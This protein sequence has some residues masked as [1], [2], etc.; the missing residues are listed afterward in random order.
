[1][2]DLVF[3]KYRA[4]V[5]AKTAL[6]GWRRGRWRR[7]GLSCICRSFWFHYETWRVSSGELVLFALHYNYRIGCPFFVHKVAWHIGLEN[8]FK[9]TSS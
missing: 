3:E 2:R 8:K 4:I 7:I 6:A 5:A 1:M 9:V